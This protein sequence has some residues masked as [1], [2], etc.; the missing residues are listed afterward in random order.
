LTEHNT[1]IVSVQQENKSAPV[2]WPGV[3][4]GFAAAIAMWLV[5]YPL[6]LPGLQLSPSVTAPI[7]L[8]VM[9]AMIVRGSK[10]LGARA[11]LGGLIA[12]LTCSLINL[13]LLGNT[14]TQKDP[15]TAEFT[16]RENATQIAGGFFLVS[17]AAGVIAGFIGKLLSKDAP[18][19]QA[20]PNWLLRFGIAA[21]AALVPLVA[22]GGAVTSAGAGMAVPD[23]PGTYGQNMFLYPITL[24]EQ[25]VDSRIFLEH[26]HR[27]F[28]TLVGMTVFVLMIVVLRVK[29]GW[30]WLALTLPFIAASLIVTIFN[31]KGYI[32]L[33]FSLPLLGFFAVASLVFTLIAASLGKTGMLT[34]GV[35]ALV[36]TQGMLGALRVTE[37]NPTFGFMHGI[38]GQLILAATVVLTASLSNS[39]SDKLSVNSSAVSGTRKWALLAI[40]T[41]LIQLAM[42]AAYRHFESGHAL[43]THIGFSL[44]ALSMTVIFAFNLMKIDKASDGCPTFKRLGM[45]LLHGVSLQMVLGILALVLLPDNAGEERV[46][47]YDELETAADVSVAHMLFATAHQALGASLLAC[48]ILAAAWTLRTKQMTE[49]S[50]GTQSTPA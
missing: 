9:V 32:D 17:I 26:T 35:F 47:M 27:L 21:V 23:W 45:F 42:A 43:M 40:G 20:Q 28:G 11:L 39:W 16:L 8:L 12:G 24:M 25:A 3:T 13:L 18:H 29:G 19:L 1:N 6:H 38:F 4:I 34:V 5:W 50:G 44:I 33:S 46:V 48:S 7:L 37:S 15:V 49:N 30:A 31:N 22:I 41:L 2:V 14:L 36:C 10:Q